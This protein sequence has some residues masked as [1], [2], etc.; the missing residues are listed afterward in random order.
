MRFSKQKI[1]S[2]NG[3]NER[4]GDNMALTK[5]DLQAISELLDVKL[6]PIKKDIVKLQGKVDTLESKVDTLQDKVD[7]LQDKVD[8]LQ[9]TVEIHRDL[10]LE[11]Y[12]K[13][14]EHNTKQDRETDYLAARVDIIE[15]QTIQNTA[16][17]KRLQKA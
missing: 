17:I 5:D 3:H 4:I 13:Q 10:T 8:T 15:K 7:T 6:D 14:M 1:S 9:E 2:Q 12:G 16:D 11:F